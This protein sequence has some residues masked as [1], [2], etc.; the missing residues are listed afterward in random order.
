MIDYNELK[1][2]RAVETIQNGIGGF[3][4]GREGSFVSVL[5]KLEKCLAP[6]KVPG[7][8]NPITC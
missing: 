3:R 4:V 6:R 8:A 5:E 7:T 1:K 2:V